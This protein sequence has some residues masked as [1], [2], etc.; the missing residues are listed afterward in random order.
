MFVIPDILANAGGVT[1][2][3]FEW[4][5]DRGGYFWDEETVNQRLEQIMVQSFDEVAAMA[6]RT[7]STCGSAR[8]CR[9][10]S[11]SRRCT[12]CA[13][14]TPRW[15]MRTPVG[16]HRPRPSASCARASARP[17]TTTC[18]AA[19][20]A[21]RRSREV[22]VREASRAPTA[23]RRSGRRRP[24]GSA[25][26]LP[27]R[28]TPRGA[29]PGRDAAGAARSWR[30]ELDRWCAAARPVALAIGGSHGLA[31]DAPRAGRP[32]AGAWA[33][34]RCRTS[35]RGSSWR[36]SSTGPARS[37]AGSRITREAKGS[38]L[39]T[40]SSYDR[41]VRGVVR[42][43]IPAALSAPGRGRGR[44][45]GGAHPGAVVPFAP[46]WRVL[47]VACGAGRHARAFEAGGRPLRRARS[48][49]QRSCASRG[50]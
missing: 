28:S 42:R 11:G 17:A 26:G 2:S 40:S 24:R 43:R 9:R 45:R 38:S 18:R 49:R 25:R 8:T 12:G 3:Y 32:T 36:S 35:W 22:E 39:A 33:R 6:A 19:R 15:S 1:V 21:T 47:D 4:V 7:A 44:T 14:C 34:S 31:P 50:T 48:L 10:S 29:R 46:G 37:C 5:Q 16:A 27:A 30:A 13:G 41:M 20:R 23:R